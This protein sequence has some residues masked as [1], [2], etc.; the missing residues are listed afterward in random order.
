MTERCGAVSKT[1]NQCTQAQGHFGCH[2]VGNPYY[3]QETW[4]TK[5][6]G[7]CVIHPNSNAKGDKWNECINCGYKS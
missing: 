3:P 5:C 6:E 4:I 1:G 2:K 7:E